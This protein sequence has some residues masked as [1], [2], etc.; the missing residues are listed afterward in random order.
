MFRSPPRSRVQN[1]EVQP[2]LFLRQALVHAHASSTLAVIMAKRSSCSYNGS[3]FLRL[4]NDSVAC[5][6][7]KHG[8]TKRVAAQVILFNHGVSFPRL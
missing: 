2:H 5:P 6:V 4:N 8:A 1:L 3:S 7:Q